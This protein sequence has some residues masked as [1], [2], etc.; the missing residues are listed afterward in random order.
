[1]ASCHDLPEVSH[2]DERR[3]A[4]VSQTAQVGLP[5]LRT[6]AFPAAADT[7]QNQ[8]NSEATPA[9]RSPTGERFRIGTS[10]YSFQDWVGPFY[11][12]GTPRGKMFDYYVQHFPTVEIN[13]SY[14]RI[15]P[16]S[17]MAQ[18]GAR[19]PEGYPIIVKAHKSL[20]HDRREAET[21]YE[22]WKESVKPLEE[23]GQMA[24]MLAQFPYAFKLSE[25]SLE[26]LRRTRDQ[27]ADYPYFAEFRHAGWMRPDVFAFLQEHRIQ[28]V[29]V[30]EPQLPGLLPPTPVLTGD[31]LYVRFHGRN[32]EQW[33][34]GGALRYDYR[35]TKPEL[36][37]WLE[38]I[39]KVRERARSIFLFF[40]NCHVGQ[41]VNNAQMMMSLIKG[42]A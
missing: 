42:N 18:I 40:N 1:L 7:P 25:S 21:N 6:R 27:F 33:W 15:L 2:E 9:Q 8:M 19:A 3:E 31:T 16:S 23:R 28:W 26:H 39:K 22:A 37:E 20:T 24:G 11:P 14:Y 5:F 38:K 10:G 29:S 32:A 17:V 34:D 30:D 35:Y 36:T 12:P 41:A 13:A 4:L